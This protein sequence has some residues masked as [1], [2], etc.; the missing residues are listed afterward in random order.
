VIVGAT[1]QPP[2]S[3]VCWPLDLPARVADM[4]ASALQYREGA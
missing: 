2:R 4:G 1:L 3:S